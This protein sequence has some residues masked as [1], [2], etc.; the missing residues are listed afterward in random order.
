[1][2]TTPDAPGDPGRDNSNVR[3][4]VALASST[5][6]GAVNSLELTVGRRSVDSARGL[7]VR[8]E[9]DIHNHNNEKESRIADPSSPVCVFIVPRVRNVRVN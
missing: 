6:L 2:Q 7:V 1:M 9:L 8:H 4:V 5:R 3:L